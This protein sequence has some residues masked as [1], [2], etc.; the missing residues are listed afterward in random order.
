M[1]EF[2]L[3]MPDGHGIIAS[4]DDSGIV[5]FVVSAGVASPIRGTEMFDLMMR[6]YGENARAVRGVWRRGFQG[7]PSVNL[8]KVNELTAQGAPL[9]EALKAT[10][11]ATR[12]SRWGLTRVT[13]LGS[14]E[15]TV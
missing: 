1:A 15:G 11:T 9:Q 13:I 4:C 2:K 14:P 6:A 3:L 8:D 7:R 5:T 10:W 12:A